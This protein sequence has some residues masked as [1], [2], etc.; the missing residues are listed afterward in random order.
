MYLQ[1]HQRFGFSC[2]TA[3]ILKIVLIASIPTLNVN[4][5]YYKVAWKFCELHTNETKTRKMA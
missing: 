1:T 3:Y 4:H 5:V 2:R